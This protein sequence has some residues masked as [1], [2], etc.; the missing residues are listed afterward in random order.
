MFAFTFGENAEHIKYKLGDSKFF[1]L[2]LK[3]GLE[4]VPQPVA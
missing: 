4:I 2:W 3:E 1:T